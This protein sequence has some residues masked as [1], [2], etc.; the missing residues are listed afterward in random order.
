MARVWTS[1][2]ELTNPEVC[3]L[4]QLVSTLTGKHGDDVELFLDMHASVSSIGSHMQGK[5]FEDVFRM[6]RHLLLPK[7]LAKVAADYRPQDCVYASE[8]L[9]PGTA[10]RVVGSMLSESANCYVL[11]HSLHGFQQKT[12]FQSKLV[13]Y[14]E[15]RYTKAGQDLAFAVA[16]CYVMTGHVALTAELL[17]FF[18]APANAKPSQ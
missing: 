13:P 6:E 4:Q 7:L 18:K 10:L 2:S 14:T 15:E 8:P 17:P 5:R 9:R 1:P 12:G 16:H 3:L 11:C